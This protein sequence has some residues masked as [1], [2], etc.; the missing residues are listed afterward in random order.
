MTDEKNRDR[1]TAAERRDLFDAR[2]SRRFVFHRDWAVE[3]IASVLRWDTE[4][5]CGK[6][7]GPMP[8]TLA[9]SL[10][11]VR[12]MLA[13][14][15]E[16]GDEMPHA[17]VY[18]GSP[19]CWCGQDHNDHGEAPQG[20]TL[21]EAVAAEVALGRELAAYK[22]KWVA[23]RNHHVKESADTLDALLDLIDPREVDAC[24]QVPTTE[25]PMF[26]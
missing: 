9:A 11:Q 16:S 24:F 19:V 17:T 21:Q 18:N 26:L 15:P 6:Q 20:E 3:V 10:S 25:G 22:G 5:S 13:E 7:E 12:T 14:R 23:V 4:V 2:F 1:S 8:A